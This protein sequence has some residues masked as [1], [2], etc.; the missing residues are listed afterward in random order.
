MKTR[1]TTY[2]GIWTFIL[3]LHTNILTFMPL[4]AL[5]TPAKNVAVLVESS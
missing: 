1:F 4:R 3:L 2:E 5:L